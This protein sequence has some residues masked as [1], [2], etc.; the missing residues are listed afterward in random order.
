MLKNIGPTCFV[1]RIHPVSLMIFV[2]ICLQYVKVKHQEYS[3]NRQSVHPINVVIR[4]RVG[5]RTRAMELRV[6][7]YRACPEHVKGPGFSPCLPTLVV[8]K[9][10]KNSGCLRPDG[11]MEGTVESTASW[12]W[13]W[14]VA[15]FDLTCVW[16]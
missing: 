10:I 11:H 6:R 14:P 16:K 13:K 1:E 7:P 2:I 15:Q 9:E 12:R 5:A 4:N 3:K 8:T